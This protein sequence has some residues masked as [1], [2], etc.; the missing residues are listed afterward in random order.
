MT[1]VFDIDGTI[2]YTDGGDYENSVPIKERISRINA[3]Y[4]AGNTIVFQT[5]RGMGRSDNCAAFAIEAFREL[6]ENQ[7]KDW[8]V[9]YH[10]LF[11]GKPSG[12]I[13]IDDRGMKDEHF[14]T[15]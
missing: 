3:L 5:A 10:D 15:N 8:G 12:D 2:C 14:F 11:L 4:D 1:Y 6:T 13:Y 7:L 9:K